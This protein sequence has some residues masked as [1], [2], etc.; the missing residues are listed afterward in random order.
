MEIQAHQHPAKPLGEVIADMFP[1]SGFKEAAVLDQIRDGWESIVGADVARFAVPAALRDGVLNVDVLHASWLYVLK[2]EH[3]PRI[4]EKVLELSGG[5]IHEVR[6][7][8]AGRN[9][10]GNWRKRSRGPRDQ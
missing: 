2:R 9:H 8:P 7:V 4:K 1:R 6:L 10:T 5:A 3:L